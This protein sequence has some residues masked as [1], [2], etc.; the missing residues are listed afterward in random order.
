MVVQGLTPG[1][2][3]VQV[4]HNNSWTF[5]D[6]YLLQSSFIVQTGFS[7]TSSGFSFATLLIISTITEILDIY[8]TGIHFR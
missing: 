2:Q 7:M 6:L 1:L 3:N 4:R 5:N 8:Q